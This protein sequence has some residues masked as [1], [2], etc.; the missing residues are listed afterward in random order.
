MVDFKIVG[1]DDWKSLRLYWA[2]QV[3][4]VSVDY[5]LDWWDP[6]K[7]QT[8]SHWPWYSLGSKGTQNPSM[9]GISMVDSPTTV[10]ILPPI[11]AMVHGNET[12]LF[13]VIVAAETEQQNGSYFGQAQAPWSIAFDFGPTSDTNPALLANVTVKYPSPGLLTYQFVPIQAIT[14]I[15]PNWIASNKMSKAPFRTWHG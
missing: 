4:P 8:E 3:A 6:T 15:D 10:F 11:N 2:G 5:T 1:Q 12:D 7:L 14:S 13:K 9:V